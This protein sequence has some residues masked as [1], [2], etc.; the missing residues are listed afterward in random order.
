MKNN[1]LNI[2]I[3]SGSQ[4]KQSQS[5]RISDLIRNLYFSKDIPTELI[6]L[7]ESNI[8]FWNEDFWDK[9]NNSSKD[10]WLPYSNKLKNADGFV[11]VVPEWGG[12]VPASL[13]NFFLLCGESELA[14]KPGFIVA[15]SAGVS[16]SYPISELRMSSY[17]N[18]KICYMPDHM[19]I[20]N[21]GDFNSD[22]MCKNAVHEK[23]IDR[24]KNSLDILKIYSEA[25][26]IIRFD[27]NKEKLNLYEYGM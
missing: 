21:V 15:I 8:P 5:R 17:K 14:H 9:E 10:I 3:I 19:I 16:G 18:T 20:R 25:F 22:A 23:T 24:L 1:S 11:F 27:E 26:R 7:S 6:D 4:R 12:M 2:C 13:K